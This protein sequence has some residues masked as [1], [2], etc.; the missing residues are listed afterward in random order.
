MSRN[1]KLDRLIE[2]WVEYRDTVSRLGGQAGVTPEQERQFLTLKASLSGFLPM[3]QEGVNQGSLNTEAQ[4]NVRG[5]TDLMNGQLSLSGYTPGDDFLN[6]WHTH[7]LYLNKYK[8]ISQNARPARGMAG[9]TAPS[10]MPGDHYYRGGFAH[11]YIRPIFNNWLTRF[12]VRMAVVAGIVI[13]VAKVLNVDLRQAPEWGRQVSNDW[14]GPGD[15]T[16]AGTSG[17]PLNAPKTTTNSVGKSTRTHQDAM[18]SAIQGKAGGS[19][20]IAARKPGTR[21]ITSD[22][23][24]RINAGERSGKYSPDGSDVFTPP[25]TP[26]VINDAGAAINRLIP[27]PVKNFL[28]PVTQKYGVE[29]T[30]AMVGIGLLLLAYMIFGR[31]R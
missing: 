15:G 31:A 4:A 7:Y 21:P 6:R 16:P 5:M 23:S 29:V 24:I 27:R 10:S 22:R 14:W 19:G 28:S 17:G 12:V 1:R 18:D 3:L 2:Q 13:L 9:S 30:V 11:R 25:Q 26:G 20:P 8:G